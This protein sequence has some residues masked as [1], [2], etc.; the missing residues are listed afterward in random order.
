[1]YYLFILYL[2][3]ALSHAF[4]INFVAVLRVSTDACQVQKHKYMYLAKVSDAQT[5][6]T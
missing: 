6:Y 5:L 1:M 4:N 3:S 2:H